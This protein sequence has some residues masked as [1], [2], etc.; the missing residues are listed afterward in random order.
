MLLPSLPSVARIPQDFCE[1]GSCW[2]QKASHADSSQAVPSVWT[3]LRERGGGLG[4]Q[5]QPQVGRTTTSLE[6]A[7]EQAPTLPSACLFT[8]LTFLSGQDP[9]RNQQTEATDAIDNGQLSWYDVNLGEE[10]RIFHPN[11]TILCPRLTLILRQ[12]HV[13][14]CGI[15][16]HLCMYNSRG[17]DILFSTKIQELIFICLQDIFT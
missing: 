9:T 12:Q 5:A 6:E 15:T 8:L 16:C 4:P 14:T 13:H 2:R 3:G 17:S 7:W 10:E 1:S 11:L